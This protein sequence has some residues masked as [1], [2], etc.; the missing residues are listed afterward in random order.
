MW[1]PITFPTFSSRPHCHFSNMQY[2]LSQPP[3]GRYRR[4]IEIMRV[5]KKFTRRGVDFELVA[6]MFT[7][8]YSQTKKPKTP[9]VWIEVGATG[10][11]G[12][13][14]K[15]AAMLQPCDR[16]RI[17]ASEPYYKNA[18]YIQSNSIEFHC[19][20]RRER[21]RLELFIVRDHVA[22]TKHGSLRCL[23]PGFCRHDY[24]N[25]KSMVV[26]CSSLIDSPNRVRGL[27]LQN[28]FRYPFYWYGG[29]SLREYP[30]MTFRSG[31][32]TR[33][34]L[35]NFL[36]FWANS[37]VK[38]FRNPAALFPRGFPDQWKKISKLVPS[39]N[40][41]DEVARH[42][43]RYEHSLEPKLL[44][45]TTCSLS[46]RDHNVFEDHHLPE[47]IASMRH[48]LRRAEKKVEKAVSAVLPAAIAE[49]VA[50][51]MPI[52]DLA[53]VHVGAERDKLKKTKIKGFF[54]KINSAS[55]LAK[56][57]KRGGKKKRSAIKAPLPMKQRK[58]SFSS[59]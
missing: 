12:F 37:G 29:S 18:K 40:R 6:V 42:P 7:S 8:F 17:R 45:S 32:H 34:E 57:R 41:D 27:I 51:M 33:D 25:R 56:K 39:V 36:E 59:E 38:A 46:G 15:T 4:S 54:Q 19:A 49:I 44:V 26:N 9:F 11:I 35:E 55:P 20:S 24:R 13:T 52:G 10:V 1:S 2:K 43:K 23:T 3:R 5:R 31:S 48:R 53:R 58:I 47:C 21:V 28:L 50:K 30:Y 22:H 14:L 16:H